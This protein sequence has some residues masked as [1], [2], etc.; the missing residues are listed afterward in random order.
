M[1]GIVYETDK[2]RANQDRLHRRLEAFGYQVRQSSTMGA[3]D[4]AIYLQGKLHAVCEYKHRRTR[5]P[6]LKIDQHKIDGLIAIGARCKVKPMLIISFGEPD[7]YHYWEASGGWPVEPF[8]RRVGAR[9]E[10][11]FPA[12]VIPTDK[13]K[14]LN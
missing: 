12:Y 2:D 11:P 3:V 10:E 1:N 6:T 9:R 5:Y 13:F 8:K 4:F 7:N 14:P